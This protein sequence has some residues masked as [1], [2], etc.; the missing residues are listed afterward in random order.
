MKLWTLPFRLLG[1]PLMFTFGCVTL[2]SLPLVAEYA[3]AEEIH[4]TGRSSRRLFPFREWLL[5]FLRTF[6]PELR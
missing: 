1:L 6:L 2:L 3:A 4:P 5:T